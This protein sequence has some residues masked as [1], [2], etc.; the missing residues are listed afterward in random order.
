MKY[1]LS[2]IW[3]QALQ[4]SY[5]VNLDGGGY[6]SRIVYG[7]KIIKDIES[8]DIEILNTMRGGDYYSP[9]N[10]QEIE[11]FHKKG[12]RYGVY[13]ISLSNYRTKLDRLE[14]KIRDEVNNRNRVKEVQAMRD[15]RDIILRK[16]SEITNKLNQLN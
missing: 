1:S 4:D 5:A 7:I 6:E 12:W 13:V 3:E 11:V 15:L 8:G 14:L 16:Y 10:Q 9:I 2:D